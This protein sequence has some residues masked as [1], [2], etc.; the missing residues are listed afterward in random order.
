M[1]KIKKPIVKASVLFVSLL[2]FSTT[3]TIAIANTEKTYRNEPLQTFEMTAE[4][5]TGAIGGTVSVQITGAWDEVIQ[6]YQ[7][8]ITYDITKLSFLDCDF[9]DSIADTYSAD[10][11]L[12]NEMSPGVLSVGAV[13]F[14]PVENMP[15]AGSGLLATLNFDVIATEAT[16][17]VV[18]I[19]DNSVYTGTDGQNRYPTI[20]D[21]TVTIVEVSYVCGDAN[22]DGRV[23]VSDAVYIINYA[24][25]GGPPPDP[26]CVGDANGDGKVNVSDAV[27]I[28][29]Y[30]FAGG[31]PPVQPDGCPCTPP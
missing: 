18:D 25:A 11:A 1:T 26:L 14:P 20:T 30:A 12:G 21:G 2:L 3:V 13:W 8:S 16:T 6:G 10:Y 19:Q 27:Y 5:A 7:M 28:I 31:A 24:F 23:N 17:T 22:G 4:D 9:T 29:N 15:P